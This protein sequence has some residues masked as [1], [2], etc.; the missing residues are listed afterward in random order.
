MAK[1]PVLSQPMKVYKKWSCEINTSWHVTNPYKSFWKKNGNLVW[2]TWLRSQNDY[3]EAHGYPA[4]NHEKKI[5]GVSNKAYVHESN[6]GQTS[7]GPITASIQCGNCGMR[8]HT[9]NDGHTQDRCTR[10]VVSAY[11]VWHQMVPICTEW[12]CTEANEATQTHCYNPFAPA[13]PIW[14]Y[15]AHGWQC[16]CQ[17]DPVSLPSS[18]LER[19]LGRPHITWLSTVQQNLKQHHL[20]LPEAADLAQNRPLWRMMST[21]GATQSWVAC[22]KRWRCFHQDYCWLILLLNSETSYHINFWCH[23]KL[24]CSIFGCRENW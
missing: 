15:Y 21:Y 13:Y 9:T 6:N 20:T 14:A 17:E 24:I 18:R 11:A 10:P 3:F 23:W 8:N 22:Q 5:N 4:E 19:H 12:W 1:W 2:R 7:A 16:R